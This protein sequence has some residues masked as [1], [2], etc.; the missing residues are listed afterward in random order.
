MSMGMVLGVVGSVGAQEN[1][2]SFP[3]PPGQP[4][5]DNPFNPPSGLAG[6]AAAA[7][8]DGWII[9]KTK[10]VV[11]NTV[12]WVLY[13]IVAAIGWILNI[14]IAVM[15]VV[16]QYNNFLDEPVVQSGWVV[17]RDLSN[18]FFIIILMVIAVGTI[19]RVPNYHYKQLL[20]KLLIMAVLINFSK[21]FTGILIDFSQVVMLTFANALVG[22][23][24]T[25]GYSIILGAIGMPSAFSLGSVA[26]LTKAEG[27]EIMDVI[28]ALIFAGII[29]SVALVVVAMIVV[30]LV[31]RVVMLWFLIILSPLAF[32]ATTFPRS[33]G[34]AGQWWDELFKYLIVGPALMFFLFVSLSALTRISDPES[35]W[36]KNNP[37]ATATLDAD[38]YNA[39]P[40]LGALG[41]D[42]K[43][44]A[45]N[46]ATAKTSLSDMASPAGVFNV[47]MVIGLLMGSLIAAQKL[48][49]AGSQ[50]AS[51]GISMIKT[52]FQKPAFGASSFVA[53]GAWG[54]A[55]GTASGINT[56]INAGV[57]KL[58]GDKKDAPGII[59]A[60]VK[61]KATKGAAIGALAGMA[62]GPIGAGAGAAVGATIG[63]TMS[64]VKGVKG[65]YN[66]L[67]VR[68]KQMANLANASKRNSDMDE[69]N[70]AKGESS[71]YREV[72]TGKNIK[73]IEAYKAEMKAG[74]KGAFGR[75]DIEDGG[76][77][78]TEYNKDSEDFK[79]Q[80]EIDKKGGTLTGQDGKEI[81]KMIDGSKMLNEEGNATS[82]VAEATHYWN[83]EKKA[84]EKLK[85]AL[86]RNENKEVVQRWKGYYDPANDKK[87]RKLEKDGAY[88]EVG[89]DQSF[90]EDENGKRNVAKIGRIAFGG[91]VGGEAKDMGRSRVNYIS[92][93]NA[94]ANKAQAAIDANE[95]EKIQEIAKAYKQMPKDLLRGLLDIEKDRDSRMA[96]AH[97]M[98]DKGSFRERDVEGVLKAK[99]AL[100]G[101]SMLRGEFDESMNKK[102]AILNFSRKDSK[103][104]MYLD[105]DGLSNK[106]SSGDVKLD[107]QN[108]KELNGEFFNVLREVHGKSGFHPML[109]KMANRSERDEKNIIKALSRD[110][111]KNS[112]TE[113][114]L[115]IRKSL[116]GIAGTFRKAFTDRDG[117]INVKELIN[118][119]KNINN[120][121]VFNEANKDEF[122][123]PEF[124]IAIAGGVSMNMLKKM[125]KSPMVDPDMVALY[126]KAIVDVANGEVGETA[127][128]KES[129]DQ[130]K[131]IHALMKGDSDLKAFYSEKPKKP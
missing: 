71:E 70:A 72:S 47:A 15:L 34:Y 44:Q 62:A 84:Y 68:Y 83:E 5:L 37:A 7:D 78:K 38:G 100:E 2:A 66:N 49:V 19:L 92:G 32:V 116:G 43:T 86:W 87:Y 130:A 41:Q 97:T 24:G 40:G 27:V 30:V 22:E 129:I 59:G 113:A 29:S 99:E 119:F 16:G 61:S 52:G 82:D 58:F 117:N 42:P 125:V 124:K 81:R 93:Y 109:L 45:L 110:V 98:G 112:F 18:N 108:T 1:P 28:A 79:E 106:V 9:T 88:Y 118:A 103:G 114:G 80:K 33:K 111:E 89:G 11:G 60:G 90:M 23:H 85:A 39:S 107:T 63:A 94:S 12:G 31:F 96:I 51:K 57:T 26:E 21:L 77:R 56:G 64:A 48:G 4:A 104:N 65:V 8:E 102:H 91:L 74:T 95:S 54:I 14:F 73:D 131:K 105:E 46:E 10:E 6:G 128:N 101:N 36:A 67:R 115:E 76:Y 121:A 50:Y 17:I 55:K 25:E 35:D 13:Y 75:W 126:A 122:D 123:S 20:P 127:A 120:P 69:D 3:N 53:K